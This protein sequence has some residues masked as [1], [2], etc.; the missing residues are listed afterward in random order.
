MLTDKQKCNKAL[1]CRACQDANDPVIQC[2]YSYSLRP[3]ASQDCS[4]YTV[5]FKGPKS[6]TFTST[7]GNFIQNSGGFGGETASSPPVNKF[8]PASTQV[9][10]IARKPTS[11]AGSTAGSAKS[12]QSGRSSVSA[13]Y[14]QKLQRR[15]SANNRQFSAAELHTPANPANA[16]PH[17]TPRRSLPT[18]GAKS[19]KPSRQSKALQVDNGR[20]EYF[21]CP[22]MTCTEIFRSRK[23]LEKHERTSH[24]E[25]YCTFCKATFTDHKIWR[26]HENTHFQKDKPGELLWHCGICDSFG[27]SEP[28]RYLHV[29]NHWKERC[30][31]RAWASEPVVVTLTPEELHSLDWM[32]NRQFNIA[33]ERLIKKIWRASSSFLDNEMNMDEP[34]IR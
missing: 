18:M 17:N 13:R 11:V 29:R 9:Y 3:T 7:G 23:E 21:R 8:L 24:F 15:N 28:R 34:K 6:S 26:N 19:Q 32:T 14:Q 31:I 20:S 12:S 27:L 1:P 22:T 30:D 16:P 5:Q 33:A 4:E 10:S 25:C 2:S